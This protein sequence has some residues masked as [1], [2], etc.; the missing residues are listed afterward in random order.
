MSKKNKRPVQKP[1]WLDK[2]KVD[3]FNGAHGTRDGWNT[4]DAPKICKNCDYAKEGEF[5]ISIAPDVMG[6]IYQLCDTV[7][8]E[9]QALL[10]GA[11]EGNVVNV[12]GY[13]IPK[14]E[15]S[16]ASVKNLDVVDEEVIAA[17]GIVAT[18]HSH[19][20]MG[21][22]F[23][24]TD[25]E[26]TNLSQIKH[27]IVVNNA[28][29]FVATSRT[30]L[31]CG[32]VKFDESS[33]HITVNKPIEVQ[34]DENIKEFKYTHPATTHTLPS[35]RDAGAFKR[36]EESECKACEGT[37]YTKK[38][39]VCVKCGGSGKAGA[40]IFNPETRLYEPA[41]EYDRGVPGEYPYGSYY[42]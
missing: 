40:M 6:V 42:D 11:I 10:L 1:W 14:Q 27:H 28:G 18:I 29:E 16:A 7:K 9:W 31:P 26:Y 41:K 33:V 34:G 3:S 15:V 37:G 2:D 12:V 20:E 22:F 35:V 19:G 17:K 30:D 24:S 23:S 25:E 13:W 8:L 39:D 36:E 4:G 21:V 38:W 5:K 32:M